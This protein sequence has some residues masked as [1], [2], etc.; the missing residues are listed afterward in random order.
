M[1][2]QTF[3]ASV[4][5]RCDFRHFKL[6]CWFDVNTAKIIWWYLYRWTAFTLQWFLLGSDLHTLA[7]AA[8]WNRYENA[9]PTRFRFPAVKCFY[10]A[11]LKCS[12][13]FD[14]ERIL[15]V[16]LGPPSM[17]AACVWVANSIRA[18]KWFCLSHK[19]KL[20]SKYNSRFRFGGMSFTRRILWLAPF[21]LSP[22]S[23]L[24]CVEVRART[25]Y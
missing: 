24:H 8:N 21:S 1:E 23:D 16:H 17:K 11:V 13:D 18:R 4:P 20:I 22:F 5:Y 15:I 3:N 9:Y 6:H 7:A 10:S 14:E 25:E 2:W 19:R 12:V